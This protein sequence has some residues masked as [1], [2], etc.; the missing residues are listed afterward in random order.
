M[1][2]AKVAWVWVCRAFLLLVQVKAYSF[3]GCKKENVSAHASVDRL[4]RGRVVA[5]TDLLAA[6]VCSF[7]Q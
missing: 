7:V 2:V 1:V 3:S 4:T 6:T 5:D